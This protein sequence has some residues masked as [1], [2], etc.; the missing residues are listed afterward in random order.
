MSVIQHHKVVSSL[1][2][3]LVANSIYYVRVGAGFSI[4]VT[5]DLGTVI[6]YSLNTSL[7][8]I[9]GSDRQLLFNQSGTIGS[10]SVTV[11]NDG[12]LVIN[13]SLATTPSSGVK[14]FSKSIAGRLMPSFIGPSG[15]DASVQPF[16]ARNKVSV[17]NPPGAATTVPGV[18]GL[19]APSALGTA[20]SRAVTATN[21]VTR[22][23]RLGY[24]S[25]TT[26]G[27]VCGIRAASANWTVGT[28]TGLGGF[29]TIIRWCASDAATVAGARMFVG[30]HVGTGNPTSAD[31]A[32]LVNCIGVAQ[33]STSNNLHIVHAG[34]AVQTPI[35]LGANFP[36]AGLSTDLYELSLFS[37]P[38]A[39]NV[40]GYRVQRLNTGDVAEGV[41]NKTAGT[42]LPS[43]STMLGFRA[44]RS[45]NATALAVGIDI[46]SV[47]IE[48]DN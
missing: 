39:N 40:V 38:Y 41:L 13:S 11:D 33:L 12:Q 7:P 42:Q 20:T 21:M 32:T 30:M 8:E 9:G 18:W 44:F 34:S 19:A 31:P 24:V 14:L 36:A 3:P 5:N 17:W 28:G 2:D 27:A 4:Y 10:S 45:N 37:H 47:Y 35:D 46:V 43:S 48:T 15:L 23:M 16:I 1:P 26:A 25:A 29:T 22:S 6:A